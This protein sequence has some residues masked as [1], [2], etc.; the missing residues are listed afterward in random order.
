MYSGKSDPENC[1]EC[2]GENASSLFIN[3]VGQVSFEELSAGLDPYNFNLFLPDLL[4]RAYD[5]V[6]PN[7]SSQ[8]KQQRRF[9]PSTAPVEFEVFL[10]GMQRQ[11][12][13]E[14]NRRYLETGQKW[15]RL[16]FPQQSVVFRNQ[17]AIA[18]DEIPFFRN[19][20]L[21]RPVIPERIDGSFQDLIFRELR[22]GWITEKHLDLRGN[23]IF[24]DL[25]NMAAIVERVSSYTVSQS[26]EGS[27]ASIPEAVHAHAF[28][29]NATNF[30]LFNRSCV[31]TDGCCSGQWAIVEITFGVI[32]AGSAEEIAQVFVDLRD[33]FQFPS[34]H[35]FQVRNDFGGLVGLYVPRTQ[36]KPGVAS[37]EEGDWKFGAFEVLGL[38][39]AKNE[40][41]YNTL[42]NSEAEEAIR[43]VTVQERNLRR[44][45][46][47]KANSTLRSL[48]RT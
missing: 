32:V 18:P 25:V 26:M 24:R 28:P 20:S 37:L 23:F 16:A 38:F 39:D 3:P 22:V 46:T 17:T 8:D 21:L 35:Y 10:S 43:S 36:E 27:G 45:F 2:I 13:E 42:T 11:D 12:Y 40:E 1:I 44:E 4:S 47:S 6:H 7:D 41:I 14:R 15:N 30:P 33:E 9:M 31:S 19:H 29:K 48:G 34:N 5:I